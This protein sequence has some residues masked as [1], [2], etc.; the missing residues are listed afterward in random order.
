VYAGDVAEQDGGD[1]CIICEKPI[2]SGEGRYRA[3]KGDT[4]TECFERKQKKAD[5]VDPRGTKGK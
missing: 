5:T 2:L 3:E 4:H 1:I